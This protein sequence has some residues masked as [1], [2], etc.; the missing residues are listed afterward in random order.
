VVAR[1][2]LIRMDSDGPAGRYPVCIV[3]PDVAIVGLSAVTGAPITRTV[4]G[5]RSG[6]PVGTD[7]G[8]PDPGVITCDGMVTLARTTPAHRPVGT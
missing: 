4:R 6:V 3:T 5:I 2:D 1:G 8:L 7:E